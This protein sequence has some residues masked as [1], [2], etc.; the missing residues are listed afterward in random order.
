MSYRDPSEGS[1]SLAN[2]AAALHQQHTS[3]ALATVKEQ[4]DAIA[5]LAAGGFTPTPEQ[6]QAIDGILG[7][8]RQQSGATFCSFIGPAGTGKSTTA[9]AVRQR[10]LTAGFR[11]GLCAPTHKACAVL[12]KAC[13]VPKSDTCT[14]ASLLGLREKQI[15][16]D[17]DFVRD[18]RSKPKLDQADVWLADEASMLHPKLLALIEDAA[19]FWTRVIFIGDAAQL[20]P[21]KLGAISPALRFTPS[22]TLTKVLRHDGAV[23]DAATEIRQTAGNRWR[24]NITRSQIGNGSSIFTYADKREW[25]HAILEMATD[26][27]RDNDPDA[28]RVIAY[29]NAEVTKI[30]T[31]IRRHVYGRQ[32]PAFVEGERLITH[33]AVKD[34]HDH[35]ELAFGSSREIQI[36]R[37]TPG[38]LIHSSCADAKPY[39]CWDLVVRGDDDEPARLI[40]A[41]DPS[42]E[43]RLAIALEQ[44]KAEALQ[45]TTVHG[46]DAWMDY[47]ELRHSFAE[48]QPFWCLTCHK[49]QGSQFR[50]VFVQ[51]RD[52]DTAN[53]GVAERRRLW[54]TAFT[55]AQRAVHLVADPEVQR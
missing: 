2:P 17:V 7:F 43:G 25:Q 45:N 34:P 35:R 19:D 48:L 21:V 31:A 20:S 5:A 18:W 52:F 32:A 41:I 1:P 12:A 46:Q 42:H 10:L 16:D 15:K 55:R 53:G 40:R 22:F 39:R 50:N 37:A 44:L 54:Y 51:G 27:Q 11:V 28:F 49:A 30:N 13:G 47:W 8:C 9:R 24:P 38:E 33:Q 4:A 36:I 6:Q 26:A 29:R 14:F 3:D 23:L